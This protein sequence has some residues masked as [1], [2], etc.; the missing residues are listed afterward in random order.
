[1][2][3]DEATKT[4]YEQY[5]DDVK[6]EITD[7]LQTMGCQPIL[8]IGSGLSKRYFDGPTWDE[9]LSHLATLCPLIDKDYAYYKQSLNGPLAVGEEFARRYQEWAWGNGR[10]Q[11]PGDMFNNSVPAQAY[12]KFQIAE[13]LR[14]L[15]PTSLSALSDEPL[16][17]NLRRYE[18]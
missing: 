7:C 13:Y 6:E 8:F 15:T 11:F 16:I 4:K 12:I 14:S 3:S 5:V 10:N 18:R 1:M 2:S 17:W 9:L